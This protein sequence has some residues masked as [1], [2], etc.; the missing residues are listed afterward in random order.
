VRSAYRKTTGLG[1]PIV[2]LDEIVELKPRL[3][4]LVATSGGYDPIHPGHISCILESKGFGDTLAVIVNGDA[5]LRA[6]KGRAFQDLATRSLIV[7]ALRAVDYVIPF[8]IETD[9]TVSKALEIMR[10]DV[11]TKGG[12]RT[13]RTTIAEWD[14]CERYGVDVIT[15]VGLPKEWSSSRFLDDWLEHGL[16]AEADGSRGSPRGPAS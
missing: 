16:S 7:S 4:K 2:S 10:P 11:F 15:G 1:A 8:E 3:G 6:K 12:D 9:M 14:V 5:F 13:D